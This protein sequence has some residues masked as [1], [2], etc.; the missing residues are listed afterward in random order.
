[1]TAPFGLVMAIY[2]LALHATPLVATLSAVAVA[3]VMLAV[4]FPRR[5]SG[6]PA[7]IVVATAYVAAVAARGEADLLAPLPAGAAFLFVE[8]VALCG[9]AAAGVE[10]ERQVI[11]RRVRAAFLV[12]VGG[13]GAGVAILALSAATGGSSALAFLVAVGAC[14]LLLVLAGG[15]KQA[16]RG[17]KG[18]EVP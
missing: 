2:P 8:G 15:P 16:Q 18:Q 5:L 12:A 3:L 1:M 14:G 11:T 6:G 13:A 7:A 4:A 10:A 17:P 9:L